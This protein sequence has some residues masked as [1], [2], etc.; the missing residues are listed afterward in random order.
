[1]SAYVYLKV[2]LFHEYREKKSE[3]FLNLYKFISDYK[4][5]C[6]FLLCDFSFDWSMWCRVVLVG[7][8]EN[9]NQGKNKY[10]EFVV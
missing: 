5:E 6:F 9:E 1:M 10:F 3:T 2:A 4:V 8:R 7:E